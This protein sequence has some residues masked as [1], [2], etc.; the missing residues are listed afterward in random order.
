MEYDYLMD[1][2]SSLGL[3][4]VRVLEVKVQLPI[5]S[6]HYILLVTFLQFSENGS[7]YISNSSVQDLRV[8][9]NEAKSFVE[10]QVQHRTSDLPPTKGEVCLA[11]NNGQWSRGQIM[12]AFVSLQ[13]GTL[14]EL[15]DDAKIGLLQ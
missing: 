10:L 7:V 6:L 8:I 4:L 13:H 2:S 12:K 15:V 5:H 3:R 14:A 1:Y 11:K 9:E